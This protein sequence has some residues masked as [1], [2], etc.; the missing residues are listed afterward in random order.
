MNLEDTTLSE[1]TSHERTDAVCLPLYN[2][3]RVVKFLETV[4]RMGVSG[5]DGVGW[6]VIV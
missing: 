4:S 2:V 1:I 3:P 5:V 6:G